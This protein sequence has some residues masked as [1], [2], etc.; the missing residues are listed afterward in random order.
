MNK[1]TSS[2]IKLIL[3]A[4]GVVTLIVLASWIWRPPNTR[5]PDELVGEWHSA[6]PNYA[7]RSFEIDSMS[8]SFRTGEGTVTTGFIKKVSV[9]PSGSRIFYTISYTV[10]DA[11]NEVSFFFDPYRGNVIQFKNQEK[12]IWTKDSSS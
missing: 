6:D 5:V 9:V 1:S 11:P 10:E 4:A 7:D 2:A 12:T 8:I 3:V